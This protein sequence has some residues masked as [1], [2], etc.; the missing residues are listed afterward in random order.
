MLSRENS[1][2]LA[3]AW[4]QAALV[5]LCLAL[6]APRLAS[7]QFGLFDDGVTL[8]NTR[9]ILSGGWTMDFDRVAGRFRPVYWAYNSL[10]SLASG[11]HPAGFYIGNLA[12]LAGSVLLVYSITRVVNPNRLTAGLAGLLFLLSGAALESFYTLSKSEPLQVFLL[13]AGLQVVISGMRPAGRTV[14]AALLFTLA[15]MVK[16]TSL[17]ILP[18]TAAWCGLAYLRRQPGEAEPYRQSARSAFIASAAAALVFLAGR[19]V[20]LS[21][22]LASGTYANNYVLEPMPMLVNALRWLAWVLRDFPYLLVA[23]AGWLAISALQKDWKSLFPTLAALV[24][25]A[26]WMAVFLPWVYSVDYYL[27]PFAAGACFLAAVFL[28]DLV[29]ALRTGSRLV[30]GLA[31]TALA[32]SALLGATTL[33][34]NYTAARIQLAADA[35]NQEMLQYLAS[36]PSGSQV[37]ISHQQESEYTKEIQIHLDQVYHRGDISLLLFDREPLPAGSYYL[38]PFIENAPLM[39]L[40]LGLD[41]PTQIGWN[42]VFQETLSHQNAENMFQVQ[43]SFTMMAVDFKHTL[44]SLFNISK[45]SQD[46][47]PLVEIDRFHYGWIAGYVPAG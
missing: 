2:R 29:Q 6:M 43:K 38:L 27:L 37:I 22:S 44:A 8:T 23:G 25:M 10:L 13:L 41:E 21:G 35:A 32:I 26:G 12:L 9:Q 34:N 16:E 46:A 42:T 17:V 5:L 47:A 45:F 1:G 14:T 40:R 18:V 15:A 31:V 24:W 36:L 19:S 39:T 33:M 11:E 20:Y 28:A 7:A 4:L 3:G 30:K